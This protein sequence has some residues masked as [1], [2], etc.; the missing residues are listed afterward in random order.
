MLADDVEARFR[1][2][3]MNI[4]HPPA[5]RILDRDHRQRGL[6]LALDR[7][8]GILEGGAGKRR[9]VRKRLLARNVRVGAGNTLIG[10]GR[11]R[12]AGL[13]VRVGHR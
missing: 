12:I 13:L 7:R 2:Q 9:H 3:V 10:D 8:K 1:Q 11:G 5:E 6:A 4:G